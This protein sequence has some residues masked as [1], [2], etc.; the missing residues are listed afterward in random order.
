[1]RAII[2]III[3]AMVLSFVGLINLKAAKVNFQINHK[4]GNEE[5]AYNK[6]AKNNLNNNFELNR[7]EYYLSDF[8]IIHDGGVRSKID[9]SFLLIKASKNS[10]TNQILD[11]NSK[12]L[13]I[14]KIEGI[15]FG[16]GV[17]APINNADPTKWP[18]NHPLAPKSP[19]MHWGWAA[20]YRF[21]AMEGTTNLGLNS[22]LEVHALNNENYKL[23]TIST[24]VNADANGDFNIVFDADYTRAL[25]NIDISG[26]LIN[27]SGEGEAVTLLNNFREYVFTPVIVSS[28]E[29]ILVNNLNIYPN[30]NN[31]EFSIDLS[32]FNTANK[33]INY[34]KVYDNLGR[35]VNEFPNI[36][37]NNLQIKIER[38]GIFTIG[39]YDNNNLIV[40]KNVVIE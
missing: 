2:Q 19:S 18:A 13:K 14:S 22:T 36:N 9:S 7:M 37:L 30:P 35:L 5:F 31:G 32:E 8:T 33:T 34:I 17:P 29:N 3:I 40:S 39:F 21:V 4:L 16:I 1:M 24:N 23:T 6:T 26:G 10:T 27:H 20:G 25:E 12:N 28:L 15:E 38:K 11:L